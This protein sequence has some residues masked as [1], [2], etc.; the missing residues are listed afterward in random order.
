MHQP[1]NEFLHVHSHGKHAARDSLM[2]GRSSS[3]P[4]CS[5]NLKPSMSAL[6]V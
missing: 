2:T 5:N 1:G 4:M 3:K 6:M